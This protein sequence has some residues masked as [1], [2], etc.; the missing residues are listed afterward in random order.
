MTFK[1]GY[2]MDV[3]F[4]CIWKHRDRLKIK[5]GNWWWV[6]IILIRKKILSQISIDW[7]KDVRDLIV[8][9]CSKLWS[10]TEKAPYSNDSI[11]SSLLLLVKCR[12]KKKQRTKK[13]EGEKR[14]FK[15]NM[16]PRTISSLVFVDRRSDARDF[17]STEMNVSF[18]SIQIVPQAAA[19]SDRAD[20]MKMVSKLPTS[21]GMLSWDW[22][23]SFFFARYRRRQLLIDCFF[24]LFR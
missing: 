9:Q 1:F 21:T 19:M 4:S 2:W 22:L 3:T 12:R 11:L 17:F 23:V 5:F 24:S 15:R 8:N 14:I 6:S 7:Q 16:W 18:L 20:K 13:K 10:R